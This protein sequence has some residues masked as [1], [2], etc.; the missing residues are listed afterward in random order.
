MSTEM[1]RQGRNL[2]LGLVVLIL[3]AGCAPSP[4]AAQDTALPVT[5]TP[6]PLYTLHCIRRSGYNDLCYAGELL[7]GDTALLEKVSRDFCLNKLQMMCSIHIWKDEQSVAQTLPLTQAE[8][9][10]RIAR[11]SKNPNTGSDCLQTYSN[12]EVVYSSSGCK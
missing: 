1:A 5:P 10:S 4:G 11:Y 9:S 2:I 7:T 6:D 12:G 3:I 8:L